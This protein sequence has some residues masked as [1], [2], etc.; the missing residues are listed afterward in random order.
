MFVSIGVLFRPSG[1]KTAKRGKY[2]VFPGVFY[3]DYV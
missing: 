2:E 1:R 3:L